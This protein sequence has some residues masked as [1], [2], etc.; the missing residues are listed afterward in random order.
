M[1]P[2]ATTLS[3]CAFLIA[4]ASAN[5]DICDTAS[6]A[7]LRAVEQSSSSVNRGGRL[8]REILRSNS[9]SYYQFKESA[10]KSGFDVAA[11]IKSVPVQAS[12]RESDSQLEE[13]WSDVRSRL[14]DKLDQSYYESI[15]ETRFRSD[16][17]QYATGLIAECAGKRALHF[18]KAFEEKNAVSFAFYYETRPDE[19]DHLFDGFSMAPEGIW[20]CSKDVGEKQKKRVLVSTTRQ[21]IKCTRIA[22]AEDQ[23]VIFT[24]RVSGEKDSA[25]ASARV[26]PVPVVSVCQESIMQTMSACPAGEKGAMVLQTTLCAGNVK[27][28]NYKTTLDFCGPKSCLPAIDVAYWAWFKM[29]SVGNRPELD[30]ERRSPEV[31]AIRAQ[32]VGAN[33]SIV[34]IYKSIIMSDAYRDRWFGGDPNARHPNGEGNA[35]YAVSGLYESMFG[36]KYATGTDA[37]DR[38]DDAAGM[39]GWGNVV[40]LSGWREIAFRILDTRYHENDRN[41]PEVAVLPYDTVDIGNRIAYCGPVSEFIEKHPE[42]S[43][44]TP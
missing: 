38:S 7:D 29:F 21:D 17:S 3:L 39:C 9:E 10:S 35:Y 16:L 22:G 12:W 2:L 41:P 5:A 37:Q 15:E 19:K 4:S 42:F 18:W 23:G 11:V 26:A 6:L 33:A 40:C 1:R 8:L 31:Q 20:D 25:D 43:K 34:S 27:G 32:L 13:H 28:E 24:L 36:P 30:K 44:P 14:E